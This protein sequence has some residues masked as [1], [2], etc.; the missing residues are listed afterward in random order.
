LKLDEPEVVRREY[1]DDR[2][3][4]ARIDLYSRVA[5]GVDARDIVFAAVEEVR[6]RRILEVGCGRGEFAERMMRG[7]GAEVLALDLSARMVELTSARGVDARIGDVRSL[8]FP[9]H[10]FDCAVAAWMLYH[11]P[12]LDRAVAELYRV[13]R[14]GGRL[15]AATNGP[16]HLVEVWRLVGDIRP[17]EESNF[18]GDNGA[19]L[20]RRRFESVEPRDIEG[21][22]VFP[23]RDAVATYV[24]ASILYKHLA[25]RVPPFEG[26]LR[27]RRSST[28]FVADKAAA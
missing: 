11:V 1:L 22:A 19:D 17:G 21:V 25:K 3:L 28:I 13:L 12:D 18:R 2:G 23:D 7:L 16:D 8:P 6:P 9:D 26:P 27:A 24:G 14:P 5:E 4:S 20:L 15:V 10:V